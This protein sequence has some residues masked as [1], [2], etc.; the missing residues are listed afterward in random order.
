M[1]KS[2]LFALLF[3]CIGTTGI[4]QTVDVSTLSDY[5]K[6]IHRL[7]WCYQA[8]REVRG[9]DRKSINKITDILFERKYISV[10]L[11]PNSVFLKAGTD[12]EAQILIGELTITQQDLND[13]DKDLKAILK[14]NYVPYFSYMYK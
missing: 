8:A 14:G 1:K 13:C 6:S 4:S 5:E 3:S 7:G 10:R 9:L 2:W 11:D 12:V